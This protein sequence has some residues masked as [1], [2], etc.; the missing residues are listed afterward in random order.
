MVSLTVNLI[1]QL[2]DVLLET[3]DASEAVKNATNY[4]SNML[5]DDVNILLQQCRMDFESYDQSSLDQL[6]VEY[7]RTLRDTS[8]RLDVQPDELTVEAIETTETNAMRSKTPF[9]TPASPW[10]VSVGNFSFR[11]NTHS[12]RYLEAHD[13]M[14]LVESPGTVSPT[15]VKWRQYKRAVQD[16]RTH[17][18]SRLILEIRKLSFEGVPESHRSWVWP[19]LLDKQ[20]RKMT[21]FSPSYSQLVEDAHGWD[22]Q[23]AVEIDR[24]IERTSFVRDSDGE[25]LRRILLAY[26]E[27]NKS[28]GYCQGMNELTG[29]LLHTMDEETSFWALSVILEV[30][31]PEYHVNSMIGLHMDCAVILSLLHQQDLELYQHLQSK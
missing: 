28:I 1:L 25:A 30:L 29:M 8:S 11:K 24:D 16:T 6:R 18:D 22:T 9:A 2:K 5:Q 31:I 3:E 27:K 14:H 15:I 10:A 17:N 4:C 7:S 19:L 23:S 20:I 12:P 26:S 21:L 13:G